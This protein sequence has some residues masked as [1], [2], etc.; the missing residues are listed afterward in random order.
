MCQY[1]EQELNVDLVM[2]REFEVTIRKD[3]VGPSPYPTYILPLRRSRRRHPLPTPLRPHHI[4][5]RRHLMGSGIL[6]HPNRYSLLFQ[7]PPWRITPPTTPNTPSPSSPSYSPT[8]PASSASPS[9]PLGVKDFTAKIISASSLRLTRS[10]E[11]SESQCQ[12]IK[13]KDVRSLSFRPPCAYSSSCYSRHLL[14]TRHP[15]FAVDF[16]LVWVRGTRDT[17][18][19]HC[20]YAL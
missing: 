2:L 15:S 14:Y 7:T 17:A 1:L 3:F 10:R 18:S 6:R 11:S 9:S 8:S 4:R 13:I 5:V 16:L 12:S 20:L 19:S